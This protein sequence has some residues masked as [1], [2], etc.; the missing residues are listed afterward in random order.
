[1]NTSAS[2]LYYLLAKGQ[3]QAMPGTAVTRKERFEN[4]L[5]QCRLYSHT[6]V[7][8]KNFA[9]ALRYADLN[10]QCAKWI[11]GVSRHQGVKC[12]FHQVVKNLRELPRR[13][14]EIKVFMDHNP[15]TCALAA[16]YFRNNI[17]LLG[18]LDIVPKPGPAY[19]LGC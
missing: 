12:I 7:F 5:Y 19:N 16:G 10:P 2:A 15:D 13:G 14:P 1:M 17:R 11:P 6:L 4:L 8:N 9:A 18:G 3:A